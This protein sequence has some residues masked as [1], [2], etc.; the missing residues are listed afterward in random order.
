[1]LFLCRNLESG[2]VLPI[3]VKSIPFIGSKRY[4]VKKVYEIVK[5]GGYELILEP[6][7]G[8]CVISANL[9]ANGIK[10]CI[11]ND[12]DELFKD[13]DKTLDAKEYVISK[14]FERGVKKS[15]KRLSADDAEYLQSL[16]EG[17]PPMTLKFLSNNFMFSAKRTNYN[18]EGV[19]DFVYFT[20]NTDVNRDREFYE[21]IKDIELESLDYKDFLDRHLVAGDKKTLVILDPPYLNSYQKAYENDVYFGLKETIDIINRCKNNDFILFN[22]TQQDIE[23]LLDV[24]GFEYDTFTRYNTISGNGVDKTDCMLYVRMQAVIN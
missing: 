8:S 12:Y 24:Y 14:M 13:F 19:Q 22:Q 4:A 17:Y 20:N 21:L 23:S 6:F 10:R 2:D 9:K 15:D 1:M 16:V 5:N 3:K 18:G 7:G 11:A